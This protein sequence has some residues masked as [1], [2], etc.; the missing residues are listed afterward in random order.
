MRGRDSVW[1]YYE[2]I[3]FIQAHLA[4]LETSV[5][6]CMVLSLLLFCNLRILKLMDVLAFYVLH[7]S[8]EKH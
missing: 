7:H 8:K 2:L 3:K 5:S 4:D 6:C 1:D